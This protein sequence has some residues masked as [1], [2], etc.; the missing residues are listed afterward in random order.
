LR[1]AA[2]AV[3]LQSLTTTRCNN[4]SA[5][6]NSCFINPAGTSMSPAHPC[7]LG[8]ALY[9]RSSIRAWPLY[10]GGAAAVPG[11]AAAQDLRSAPLLK[12][13]GE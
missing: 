10:M 1:N 8:P 2:S 3:G 9:A 7:S 12:Q 11:R 4:L 6:G 5:M 13:I